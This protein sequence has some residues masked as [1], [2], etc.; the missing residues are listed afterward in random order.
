MTCTLL[1]GLEE[2]EELGVRV[3]VLK[4]ALSGVLMST[5]VLRSTLGVLE[6]GVLISDW[7]PMLFIGVPGTVEL[8]AEKDHVKNLP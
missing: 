6:L 4:S 1:S 3:G 5:G 8:G 7:V 2:V